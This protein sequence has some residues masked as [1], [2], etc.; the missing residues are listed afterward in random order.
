MIEI[1]DQYSFVYLIIRLATIIA[2][3][4]VFWRQIQ[5]A[6]RHIPKYARATRMTLIAV[7]VT[8]IA[9]Q[10]APIV[11]NVYNLTH[12]GANFELITLYRASN[13]LSA[14]ATAIGFVA[15]Y[16]DVCRLFKRGSDE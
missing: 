12:T 8:L 16:F 7:V 9:A 14:A 3:M 13:A 11:L 15:I 1:L 2:L 4:A 5:M 6:K 10:I